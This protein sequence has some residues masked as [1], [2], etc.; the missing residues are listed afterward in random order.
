MVLEPSQ[1]RIEVKLSEFAIGGGGNNPNLS[2]KNI[3]KFQYTNYG[4]IS[5]N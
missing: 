2:L 4:N 5:P 1:N 3:L